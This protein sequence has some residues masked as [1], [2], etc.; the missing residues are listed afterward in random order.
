MLEHSE[1]VSSPVSHPK[2]EEDGG[3]KYETASNG[4]GLGTLTTELIHQLS[5]PLSG[6]WE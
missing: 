4:K 5:L 6:N 2:D 1:L 3:R